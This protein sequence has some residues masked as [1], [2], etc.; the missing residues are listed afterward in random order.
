MASAED[1]AAADA[2]AAADQQATENLKN[3]QAAE[4][5]AAKAAADAAANALVDPNAPQGSKTKFKVGD[6]A[7]YPYREAESGYRRSQVVGVSADGTEATVIAVDGSERQYP[8]ELLLNDKEV[9]DAAK[10]SRPL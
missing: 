8:S 3:Q 9:V 1:K 6:F 4:Q 10:L 7:N 2:Q 5:A